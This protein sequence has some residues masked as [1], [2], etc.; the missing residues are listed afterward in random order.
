MAISARATALINNLAKRGDIMAQ[1]VKNLVTANTVGTGV[2]VKFTLTTPTAAGTTGLLAS[3][4]SNSATNTFTITNATFDFPR[5][6]RI[7]FASG[8][9]GGNV[10]LV[11]LDARGNALTETITASAGNT[12]A[13][14]N[15]FKSLTSA[16][17]S[18]VGATGNA[19]TGGVGNV[20]ATGVYRLADRELVVTLTDTNA[21]DT[22]P[23]LIDMTHSTFTMATAPNGTHSYE[24]D[25]NAI[26]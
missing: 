3:L 5:N 8:W 14:V 1:A 23:T 4:A 7:A 17:K 19:A 25:C 22:A 12:V 9:D 21:Q 15:A 11:G 18:A 26:L 6:V 13:S 2:P 24:V 20:F 16:T 10:A